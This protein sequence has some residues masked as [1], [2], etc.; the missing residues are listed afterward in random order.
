M[1]QHQVLPHWLVGHPD[2][3]LGFPLCFGS[4]VSYPSSME[5]SVSPFPQTWQLLGLPETLAILP[6]GPG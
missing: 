4:L 5:P 3:P 2:G 6:R 1:H